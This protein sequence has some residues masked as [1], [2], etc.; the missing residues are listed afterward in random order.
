MTRKNVI[1]LAHNWYK[2]ENYNCV[3]D[4]SA[5]KY[6]CAL[7]VR[8]AL[9]D[10][11]KAFGN[12]TESFGA[13]Y[14]NIIEG[15]LDPPSWLG[16]GVS[17]HGI[18]SPLSCVEVLQMS[19]ALRRAGWNRDYEAEQSSPCIFRF[20]GNVL[21]SETKWKGCGGRTAMMTGDAVSENPYFDE[22][23]WELG[24]WPSSHFPN[25]F[26]SDFSIKLD[27]LASD[28]D[29]LDRIKRLLPEIRKIKNLPAYNPKT[30]DGKSLGCH[31]NWLQSAKKDRILDVIDLQIWA[32]V[33]DIRLGNSHIAKLVYSDRDEGGSE[34]SV[35]KTY[36]PK[37]EQALD[38]RRIMAL[39]LTDES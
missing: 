2:P 22:Y 20:D 23:Y 25:I 27:L 35:A 6:A 26:R 15:D 14:R 38:E 19:E 11:L 8:Y 5:K 16:P 24:A 18:A 10:C 39:W 32:R 28:E 1:Q 12:L 21:A 17:V 36:L 13:V 37:V 31:H 29:I 9:L 7:F 30:K 34:S 3:S 4:Y 33:N